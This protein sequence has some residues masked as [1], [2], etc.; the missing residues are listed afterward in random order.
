MWVAA[1]QA[2]VIE[3]A[4][5][6]A[7]PPPPPE[8]AWML[9]TWFQCQECVRAAAKCQAEQH[10]LL[11]AAASVPVEDIARAIRDHL[12]EDHESHCGQPKVSGAQKA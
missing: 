9:R 10:E 11:V 8:Y 6:G 5:T 12:A 3:T 4:I 1:I 7:P 2:A